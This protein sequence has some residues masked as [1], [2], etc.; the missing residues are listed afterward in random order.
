MRTTHWATQR[1]RGSFILMKLTVWL[2]RHLP[3]WLLAPVLYA[4]VGYFFIFA[5]RARHSIYQYQTNLAALSHPP[6]VQ[7]NI[8]SVFSQFMAFAHI[9]LDKLDIWNGRLPFDKVQLIDPHG[10]NRHLHSNA[11]G[12]LFITA[13]L[14]NLDVCHALAEIAEKVSINVLV[15]T[16][17]AQRFNRLLAENGASNLHLIQ[18]SEL[19]PALLLQLAQRIERGQWLVIT[20]DRIPLSS[21]RRVIANFLG[22]PAAFPQGPWLLAMLLACPINTLACLKIAGGY[23]VRVAPLTGPIQCKRQERE[24]LIQQHVQRYSAWLEQQCL[25]AP[26]QW[27]N[28]YPFWES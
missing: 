3:R 25:A 6:R 18:I 4:I 21:Q 20:G 7:P 23:Q 16:Q 5:R 1:E 15:H 19:N 14:G 12:Q 8:A 27:F 2:A 22:K 26:E 24:R 9:L 17:H 10:V 28:F 13:H 11:R